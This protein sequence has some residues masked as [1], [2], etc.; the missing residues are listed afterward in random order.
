MGYRI[1]PKVYLDFLREIYPKFDEKRQMSRE[2][3]DKYIGSRWGTDYRTVRKHRRNMGKYGI[4]SIG[5]L[6]VSITPD[7]SKIIQG[8]IS[9][10]LTKEAQG[11]QRNA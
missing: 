6:F 11:V 9:K 1:T 7:A 3:M 4:L 2:L 8:E 5:T 10:E